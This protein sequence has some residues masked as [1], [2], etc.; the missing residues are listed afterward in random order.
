[1]VDDT[2][3]LSGTAPAGSAQAGRQKNS[4]SKT[5]DQAREE[6]RKAYE[7]CDIGGNVTVDDIAGYMGLSDKTIYDRIKK[8]NGEFM[9][10]PDHRGVIIRSST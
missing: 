6:F 10:D 9:L 2:G 7:A 1:M 5:S 3:L 8:S 4:R